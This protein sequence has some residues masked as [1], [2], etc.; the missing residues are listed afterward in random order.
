MGVR[1]LTT[2]VNSNQDSFLQYYLLHDTYL[3]IDGNSMCAQLYRSLNCFSAFGGDYDKYAI[4]VRNFF[5]NFRKCNITPFVIFDGSHE[6]RKLKTA[7]SRLRSKINGAS[8]LDAV[9][10]GSLQIF[11][12]LLREV[13]KQILAEMNILYTVCEFEADDEIA[14]MA[15]NL[16][17]PVLSYD[18]DFFIYNVLYIPFNTLERK[19]KPF[20]V[21]GNKI[22]AM[23]CKIYRVQ[24]LTEN[25]GGLKEEMLPLLATLLGN[26][27]VEK[28][29]FNKFFSQLKLPKSK[30]CKNEQQRCIHGIFKWL[31]NETLDSAIFKILGRVRKAHKD[32]VLSVIKQ[33][34]DGYNRKHCKSLKY[35]NICSETITN[36]SKEFQLTTKVDNDSYDE[37]VEDSIDDDSSE[38]DA[39]STVGS[40]EENATDDDLNQPDWYTDAVRN[41]HIPQSHLNLFTHHLYFCN[42]QAEDY[43]SEDSFLCTLPILRYIFDISTDFSHDYCTYVSREKD[44]TYRRIFVGREHSISRILEVPFQELTGEQLQKYFHHFLTEKLPSLDLNDLVLLPNNFQLYMISLLWWVINCN[45]PLAHVHSLFVCYLMLEV[46]DERTGT[47]RGHKQFVQNYSRK[48]DELKKDNNSYI[49][50]EVDE[51]FLNKCKVQY[52][53]CLIAANALLKHFEIDDSIHKR[54][55]SYDVKKVHSF[56]QFQCCLQQFNSLNTLC[57]HPYKSTKYHK[58]FNGTFVYNIALKL[59]NQSDPMKFIEQYLYG[60]NSV[61]MFYRSLC[62]IYEKCTIKMG[63]KNL[64]KTTYKKPRRRR[65]KKIED[66]DEII[67]YFLVDGFESEVKI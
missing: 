63:L 62:V 11:P 8:R 34:I 50:K 27:Y 3:I 58:C 59:E 49:S 31:Q 6:V 14:T 47:F 55:K 22:Q 39:Q 30:K 17:C 26:D 52:E 35:F 48:I 19:A 56:A 36:Y 1:G 2:Y 66:V 67:N 21:D 29:V 12:L 57:R 4:Y 53:D 32:K 15:R 41:N 40:T 28:R 45:V 38:E 60:S 46:V 61:L 37:T 18:S 44:S 9:T 51:L 43:G 16:K 25:F 10:Q 65:N 64:I 5:K 42:P 24:Y 13:F 33:S 23:E 7:Y 54:P 20:Y